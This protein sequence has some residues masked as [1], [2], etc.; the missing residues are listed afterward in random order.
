[1]SVVIVNVSH[2]SVIFSQATITVIILV[3]D[4]GYIRSSA[5]LE[6]ITLLSESETRM[7]YSELRSAANCVSE[8]VLGTKAFRLLG[9]SFHGGRE[10]LSLGPTGLS[11][12]GVDAAGG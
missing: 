8:V 10:M 4:A 3:M 9:F 11:E 5:A 7:A 1:M 12:G 6:A 2:I